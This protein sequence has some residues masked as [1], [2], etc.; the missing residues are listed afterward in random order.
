VCS[1]KGIDV[2]LILQSEVSMQISK[3]HCTDE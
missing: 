2:I 3:Q 1:Y